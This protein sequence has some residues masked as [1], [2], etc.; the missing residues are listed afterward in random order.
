LRSHTTCCGLTGGSAVR[1]TIA[2]SPGDER[3]RDELGL[4]ARRGEGRDDSPGY[5]IGDRRTEVAAQDVQVPRPIA[6]I[7]DPRSAAARSMCTGT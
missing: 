7:R 2:S 1:A 4:F 6:T 5:V 3:R